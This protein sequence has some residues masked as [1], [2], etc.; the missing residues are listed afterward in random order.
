MHDYA[1]KSWNYNTVHRET[2]QHL[3]VDRRRADVDRYGAAHEG[4]M[5]DAGFR[6]RGVWPRAARPAAGLHHSLASVPLRQGH[7]LTDDEMDTPVVRQG[8]GIVQGARI[9][10][11]AVSKPHSL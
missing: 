4:G 1:G 8:R 5:G 9:R 2:S 7:Y 11:R 6:P 10:V 3:P